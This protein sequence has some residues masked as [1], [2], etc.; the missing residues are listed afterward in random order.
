L[1]LAILGSV[2]ATSSTQ[3]DQLICTDSLQNGWQNWRWAAVDFNH[4]TTI[5]S[6]AKSIGVIAWRS[7]LP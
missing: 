1:L 6:N 3:A 5:Q 7:A 4:A 2:A